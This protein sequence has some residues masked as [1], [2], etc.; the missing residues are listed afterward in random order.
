MYRSARCVS[1]VR[2]ALQ[3]GERRIIKT[4]PGRGY[5]FAATVSAAAIRSV[6]AG[7]ALDEAQP[8]LHPGERRQLTVMGCELVG[9]AALSA[10]L[11]PEDLRDAT[12]ACHRHCS[13]IIERHHGCVARYAGDGLLAYFGYPEARE[14]GCPENAVRAA[15]TTFRNS[16][17]Q[18]SAD[19]QTHI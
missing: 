4:I 18:L 15:L 10:R 6:A 17:Q 7:R 19:L 11:D 3:D 12:A 16:R 8:G 13:E 2:L 14:A 9:L 5:L 1:D